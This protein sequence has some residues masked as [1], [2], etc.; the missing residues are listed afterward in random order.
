MR[1]ATELQLT[2]VAALT[3]CAVLSNGEVAGETQ[4]TCRHAHFG[5]KS[6]PHHRDF[7]PRKVGVF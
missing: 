4:A 7:G 2:M 3:A 1:K 6:A 5:L